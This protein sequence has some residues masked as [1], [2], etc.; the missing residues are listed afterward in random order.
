MNFNFKFSLVSSRLCLLLFAAI[1]FTAGCFGDSNLADVRGTVT[2]D[3]KPVP[4]AFITFTP[5]SK[6]ATSFGKTDSD[7]SYRM[8]F[9]DIETGVYIGTNTV[10]IRTGDVKSDNSGSTKEIIPVV[11]NDKTSLVA[12]VNSGSNTFDWKLDSKAGKVV[13]LE[14]D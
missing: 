2:I 3:G 12:E 11:Y 7:G 4:D 9:T 5:T 14:T 6:G 13:Q 10:C 1:I 8:R